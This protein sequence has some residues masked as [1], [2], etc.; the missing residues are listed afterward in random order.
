ML[1]FEYL[2][3]PTGRHDLNRRLERFIGRKYEK[4][5]KII[6]SELLP[7]QADAIARAKRLLAQYNPHNPE[8]DNPSTTVHL[9]V[10]ELNKLK[11]LA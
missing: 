8:R 6:Y 3:N 2:D 10:E 9:L 11:R 1:H 5:D 4:S 7:K